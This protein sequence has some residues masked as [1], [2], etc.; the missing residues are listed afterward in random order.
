MTLMG[1]LDVE[2]GE[3]AVGNAEMDLIAIELHAVDAVGVGMVLWP[4]VVG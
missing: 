1:G 2:Y 4:R 3:G